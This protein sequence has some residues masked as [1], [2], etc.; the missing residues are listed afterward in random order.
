MGPLIAT[1]IMLFVFSIYI[2]I[3]FKHFHSSYPEMKVGFHLWEVC[4]N[5]DTWEYGNNL[6]GKLAIILGIALF[7]II[8]PILLYIGLKRSYMTIL[9]LLLSVIYFLLLY[10]IVKI[11]VRKKFNLKDE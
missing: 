3:F 1:D 11:R 4:Y 5:K 2:G 10:F 9:I 7:G 8:Y 6:S